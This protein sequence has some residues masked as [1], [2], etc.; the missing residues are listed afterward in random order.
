MFLQDDD[1]QKFKPYTHTVYYRGYQIVCEN[2][3]YRL[4]ELPLLSFKNMSA[5]KKEIDKVTK[6]LEDNLQNLKEILNK[7]TPGNNAGS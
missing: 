6:D 4:P 2:G 5:A 3:D 1:T 7:K